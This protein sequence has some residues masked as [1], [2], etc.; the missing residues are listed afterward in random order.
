MAVTILESLR[1]ANYVV[2]DL[3][4]LPEEGQECFHGTRE[5]C[6]EFVASQSDYFMYEVVHMTR[7]EYEFYNGKI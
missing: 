7:E 3:T 4:Y 1:N 5:E 2:L 6:D